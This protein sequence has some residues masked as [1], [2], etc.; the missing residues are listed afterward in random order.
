MKE[1]NKYKYYLY[2]YSI[3]IHLRISA[4]LQYL[5]KNKF[6]NVKNQV[7]NDVENGF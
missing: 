5:D 4:T 6:S 1:N 7:K 3:N 2:K